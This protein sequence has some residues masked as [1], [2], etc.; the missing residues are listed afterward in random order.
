MSFPSALGRLVAHGHGLSRLQ[1]DEKPIILATT[2]RMLPL[3][4]T[5]IVT[6]I[7]LLGGHHKNSTSR[8][9]AIHSERG[10]MNLIVPRW[11]PSDFARKSQ[12]RKISAGDFLPTFADE[13]AKISRYILH[14]RK[15]DSVATIS[16]H[17]GDR[18]SKLPALLPWLPHAFSARLHVSSHI[19]DLSYPRPEQSYNP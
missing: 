8:T 6:P 2:R 11:S 7:V 17:F 15:N 10:A 4:S 9:F 12:R 16:T 13:A 1:S 19:P 3:H 18:Q 14:A 5:L